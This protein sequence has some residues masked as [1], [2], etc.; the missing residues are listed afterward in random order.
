MPPLARLGSPSQKIK[1]HVLIFMLSIEIDERV[2]SSVLL[3]LL[4]H[5]ASELEAAE[6]VPAPE[7]DIFP[8]RRAYS[9][10]DV[11]DARG[12]GCQCMETG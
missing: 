4:A 1:S 2:S 9:H 11:R 8:G 10:W 3:L 12:I 6:D 5:L 7:R